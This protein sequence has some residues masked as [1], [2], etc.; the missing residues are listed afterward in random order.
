MPGPMVPSP[1]PTPRAMALPALRPAPSRFAPPPWAM[2]SGMTVRSMVERAPLSVAF[3]SRCAAEV[4][5]SEGRE[6]ESLERRDQDD[7][8]REEDDGD[9]QC[10]RA[11][12]GES[13]QHDQAA[14]HEQDQQVAGQDVGEESDAEQDDAHELG[15]HLDDEDEAG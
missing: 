10:D 7:L 1:A 3:G 15:D 13:E 9:G 8:E 5:G 2:R 11:E 12:R 4:D 14:A 6:D